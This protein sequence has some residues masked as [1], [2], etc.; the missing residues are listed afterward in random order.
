[1]PNISQKLSTKNADVLVAQW[2]LSVAGGHLGRMWWCGSW[3]HE[4]Q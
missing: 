4:S 2:P 3:S 1:M